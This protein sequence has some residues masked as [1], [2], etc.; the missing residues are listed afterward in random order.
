MSNIR[1][2]GFMRYFYHVQ[3][4]PPKEQAIHF[5]IMSKFTALVD[6][7]ITQL[8]SELTVEKIKSN[9]AYA[10]VAK[11][12]HNKVMVDYAIYQTNS[13]LQDVSE[14]NLAKFNEHMKSLIADNKAERLS[15]GEFVITSDKGTNMANKQKNKGKNRKP[16]KM[17]YLIATVSVIIALFAGI[18]IGGTLFGEGEPPPRMGEGDF[19]GLIMPETTD[20]PPDA[21]LITISIDRSYFAVPR[22]DVQLQGIVIDDSSRAGRFATITL[23]AFDRSDFF[24]HV[25]GHTWGFSTDPNATRIE[26]YGGGTYEFSENVR[27]YRVL[28]RFGG[29]NGTMDNPYIIDF[30][31]QLHLMS[32]EQMRGH[33]RQT[34]NLYFPEWATHEPINT[35]NKLQ[36][37]PEQEKPFVYDGGGFTIDGINAPLFGRVS[38]AVIENVNIRN[39]FIE[40]NEPSNMGF[41]VNEAFNFRYE[42]DGRAYETGETIIRNSSVNHSAFTLQEPYEYEDEYTPPTVSEYD[43]YSEYD[44]YGEPVP[45]SPPTIQ[46]EFVIGGITGLGGQIENSYVTDVG[47]FAELEHHFLYAGGISGKPANVTNSGVYHLAIHGKIFHVGGIVGSASGSRLYRADGSE[48]AIFHGGNIQGNFVRRFSANSTNSAGGIVGESSTNSERAM[49][50]NNYAMDLTL[51][52]GVFADEERTELISHGYSGGIVGSDGSENHGHLILNS[53]SPVCYSVIGGAGNNTV[54]DFGDDGTVW[55]APPHAFHQESILEI[56]NRNAVHPESPSETELF[57]GSFIFADDER[58]NQEDCEH[59]LPFP[60]GI[61]ELLLKY[62]VMENED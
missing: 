11:K 52:A 57:A 59:R 1:K 27:L 40:T 36:Y 17:M 51:S 48:E 33:F 44:D 60:N 35:V 46:A 28:T 26:F 55:L 13:D 20:F 4:Q 45:P 61:A 39:S 30:Y 31:D 18:G 10:T 34:A 25:P 56:L 21:Q 49:I 22:E 50:S 16:S 6:G 32:R 8:T 37:I 2:R 23:P 41:I 43:E 7:K 14:T 24:H 38:G 19:E 42:V 29:G 3:V 53:V 15:S 58:N 54:Y 12:K 62:Y 9:R 5:Y 47:I